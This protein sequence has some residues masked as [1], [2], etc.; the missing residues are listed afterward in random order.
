MKIFEIKKGTMFHIDCDKDSALSSIPV[1]LSEDFKCPDHAVLFTKCACGSCD[2]PI[3]VV[4]ISKHTQ[5]V[6]DPD[7]LHVPKRWIL[8]VDKQQR[9]KDEYP[10]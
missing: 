6:F 9:T 5:L 2:R 4:G 8:Q 10:V 1:K 3:A 7:D